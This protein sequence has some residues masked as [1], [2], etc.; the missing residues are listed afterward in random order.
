MYAKRQGSGMRVL[1]YTGFTSDTKCRF[2]VNT[3]R[4]RQVHSEP[5]HVLPVNFGE[6]RCLRIPRLVLRGDLVLERVRAP[7]SA[8]GDEFACQ[9]SQIR[10]SGNMHKCFRVGIHRPTVPIKHSCFS[11]RPHQQR[12]IRKQTQFNMDM[13]KLTHL[14]HGMSLC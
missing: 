3:T 7:L 6:V 12:M 11:Y 9:Q 13:R 1:V 14:Y 4:A 10:V 2:L 8:A 5:V